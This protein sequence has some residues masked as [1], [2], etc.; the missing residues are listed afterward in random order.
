MSR[1]FHNG[2]DLSKLIYLRMISRSLR[3][4]STYVMLPPLLH[5]T[6]FSSVGKKSQYSSQ[7]S[8]HIFASIHA[9]FDA[10]WS[11]LGTPLVIFGANYC[12]IQPVA[13][14]YSVARSCLQAW[15]A[16]VFSW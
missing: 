8:L 1:R 9:R 16:A 11:S 12:C 13:P 2:T 6:E 5:R 14:T 7:R 15:K 10:V 4:S 3:G